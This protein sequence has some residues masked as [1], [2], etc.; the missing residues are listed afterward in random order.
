MYGL[1]AT[2]KQQVYEEQHGQWT[3]PYE[4]A[5]QS[6]L[7]QV[8][9]YTDLDAPRRTKFRKTFERLRFGRL[10][11]HLRHR[12]PIARAGYSLQIFRLSEADLH[13]ALDGRPAELG[14]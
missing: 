10:C 3:Q 7:S 8:E 9:H 1:S 14:P 2:Y 11:A 13:A 6:A 12:E 5:Y 4:A